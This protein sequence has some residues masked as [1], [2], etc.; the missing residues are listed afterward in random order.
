METASTRIRFKTAVVVGK[1]YPPHRGHKFLIDT[2]VSRSDQVTVIVCD[3]K[4]EH[5]IPG[6]IRGQWLRE[7]HP[8]VRVLVIDDIYSDDD[9][10][11]WA[12]LTVGWLGQAPEAVFTSEDYGDRYAQCMGARHIQVDRARVHIPCS[13][14]AIRTNPFAEWDYLE[15]PVRAWF[16]K[17]VCVLGAESTGTTTLTRA[18]AEAL[19]TCWVPEYGREYSEAKFKRGETTWTSEEF[20]EIAR[21]QNQREETATRQANKFL[22]CDTNSFATRLWH[23]RYVGTES[24]EVRKIA[25]NAPCHLYIL[26]GDEIPFVQ[27]G[28]RDGEHLRHQMQEWF[29]EALNQQPVVW[30]EIRGS[31]DVRLREAM[32]C[33]SSL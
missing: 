14:T 1:F 27:D 11:E 18:L 31:L 26:T 12:Q 28:F 6:E 17:R 24:A 30:R 16:V 10:E 4:G 21:E 32:R 13:G 9:S 19:G 23:R 2:A 20:I 7:I 8:T 15:P 22:I 33:V 5:T 25:A 29:R 3:K